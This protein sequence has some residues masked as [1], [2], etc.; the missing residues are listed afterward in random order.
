MEISENKLLETI[1][2]PKKAIWPVIRGIGD[3]GAVV[4]IEGYPYVFVQDAL[5]E[6]I[7]F[8]LSLQ[9]PFDVGI[10]A[11]NVNVSDV[12][13]MGAEPTYFLVT[14]GIPSVV[15]LSCV[16]E[17]YRGMRHAGKVFGASLIGGDTVA[18][19]QDFFIDISMTG[20]LVIPSYLGRDTAIDG[21]YIGVTGPL[22]ESAYG[23][24]LLKENPGIRSNRYTRR[25]RQAEPPY[26]VWKS[27]I[28][29]AIP[30]AMMDISDG[31]VIDTERMMK[32][33]DKKAV[34]N[35]EEVPMPAIL[36]K[37]SKQILALSGGEDYQFLF[38]FSKSKLAEVKSIQSRYSQLSV[39]GKVCKGHGVHLYDHGRKIETPHKGYQHFQ[40]GPA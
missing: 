23:L 24:E 37:K 14:I 5:V 20:R 6:G 34:I 38:T 25:Y 11:V 12:L 29:S 31:L 21:D 27:L 15:T 40:G 32:E 8:D 26:S 7:H 2:P 22:G 18:T 19:H 17:L 33:S 1:V 3:D 28:D 4:D 16:R 9:K 39:I 10:K 36:K 35:L 13:A 30:H